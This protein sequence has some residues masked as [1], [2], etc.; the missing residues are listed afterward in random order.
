[1]VLGVE[2]EDVEEVGEDDS[3]VGRSRAREARGLENV[4]IRH[5]ESRRTDN[6][7]ERE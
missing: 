5:R 3:K 1:M 2:E 7:G 4:R 6:E